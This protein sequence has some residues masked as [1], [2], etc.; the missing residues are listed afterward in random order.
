MT[1]TLPPF[2]TPLTLVLRAK[3]GCRQYPFTNFEDLAKWCKRK[4]YCQEAL[5]AIFIGTDRREI[6]RVFGSAEAILS[7]AALVYTK[8]STGYRLPVSEGGSKSAWQ[9]RVKFLA[10]ERGQS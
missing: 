4:P 10:E 8:V 1:T 3:T 2:E 9:E 5:Q 6:R 7:E